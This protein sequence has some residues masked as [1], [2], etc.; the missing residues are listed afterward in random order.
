GGHG[1]PRAAGRG[2]G[3]RRLRAASHGP[4][5]A[6]RR[7]RA[8]DVA[9]RRTGRAARCRTNGPRPCLPGGAEPERDC[10]PPGLAD[11]DGQNADPAGPAPDADCA[12]TGL[13]ADRSPRRGGRSGRRMINHDEARELLELATVQP[14]GLD[15]LAAGDT[16]DA[17]VLAGCSTCSAE[18]ARLRASAGL[19]REA[20][21]ETPPPELRERT[22]ALVRAVGRPR[23]SVEPVSGP[24]PAAPRSARP[25]LAPAGAARRRSFRAIAIPLGLAA[26]IVLV[27][28]GTAAVVAN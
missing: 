6:P 11:R 25:A 12:G 23:T 5:G 2:R 7:D 19:I 15:R 27:V 3:R 28:A 17:A 8:E 20:I 1:S 22:L 4:G 24:M 21:L 16:P 18:A 14:G 9:R 26:A 13:H 10:R